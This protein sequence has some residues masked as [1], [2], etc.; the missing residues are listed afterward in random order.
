[1]LLTLAML[2]LAQAPAPGGPYLDSHGNLHASL[3]R[4]SDYPDAETFDALWANEVFFDGVGYFQI[5]RP[6]TPEELAAQTQFFGHFQPRSGPGGSIRATVRTHHPVDEEYRAL[7]GTT[8]ALKSHIVEVVEG[9]DNAL[10]SNWSINLVPSTGYAWDSNDSADIS[11]LLDEAYNEGG[12]LN[13]QCLMIAYSNDS[14]P[15]GAIGVG[16]LGLPRCLVKRYLNTLNEQAITQH[17][18]GHTYTLNHC[19]DNNCIM[20][21]FL[22]TGAFGNFHNYNEN[23]S[24]QNHTS[25]MNAQ[26]NRYCP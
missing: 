9:A 25:V 4:L 21:S 17:E 8:A 1:M 10:E 5:D 3:P 7:Y 24:N 15:G 2:A 12:G 23:C 22:D 26:R 6:W 16:Y 11:S 14:T 13:G 19:C 18:V 20:Q